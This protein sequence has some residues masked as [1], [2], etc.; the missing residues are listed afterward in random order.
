MA[1]RARVPVVDARRLVL[2]EVLRHGPLTRSDIARRLRMTNARLSQV[3]TDL[4]ERGLL[5][6]A[7]QPRAA[8]STAV[9][10]PGQPL[11]VVPNLSSFVGTWLGESVVTSCLTNL[12]AEITHTVE[13]RLR[14][15]TVD[16]VTAVIVEQVATLRGGADP[17]GGLGVC[18]AGQVDADGFVR[19]APF[20]GWQGVPLGPEL[21]RLTGIGVQVDNDL[22]GLTQA[23]HWFGVGKEHDQFAVV[24]LGAGIG[25]G[26]VAGDQRL[27][28]PDAG[29]GLVSHLPVAESGQLCQQG[30]RGCARAMLSIGCVEAALSQ[31]LGRPTSFEQGLTLAGEGDPVARRIFEDG[32]AALGRLLGMVANIA[33]PRAIVVTGEGAGLAL[34][35]RDQVEHT[36]AGYRHA[37]SQPVPLVIRT[38]DRG[39]WARG[40]AARAIQQFAFR[41][42]T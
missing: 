1:A 37:L 36:L 38:L 39:Q 2:E 32:A 6:E 13:T 40:A 7:E 26:V 17:A 4:L 34:R 11:E 14:G 22:T 20:L 31:G 3:S 15:H 30:H 23:E 18:L 33:L 25:L 19:R 41:E 9:G 29:L 35:Y 24:S 27:D 10:R 12:R 16:E 5:A 8:P 28:G 21:A 42:D